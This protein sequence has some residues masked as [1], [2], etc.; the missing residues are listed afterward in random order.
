MLDISHEAVA[1]YWHK[2]NDPLI[3]RVIMFMESVESWSLDG[4]PE[5]ENALM[6]FTISLNNI[7]AINIDNVGHEAAFIQLIS[8][9]KTGRGLRLLQA[10]DEMHPGS[11]SK[12]LMHAE[13]TSSSKQDYSTFFLKRNIIF[14]RLRLLTRAFSAKRLKLVESAIEGEE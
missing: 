9:L 3:Y 6:E 12:V 5:L 10:I 1:S 8:Q 13:K 14:E 4:D 7:S 2:F 11:A